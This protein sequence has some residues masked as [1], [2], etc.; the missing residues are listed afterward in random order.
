[1]HIKEEMSSGL[2]LPT[3]R[4]R[5]ATATILS[6]LSYRGQVCHLLQRLSHQSRAFIVSQEGLPGFLARCDVIELI[7]SQQE[8]DQGKALKGKQQVCLETL[9]LELAGLE[10]DQREQLLR[11]HYP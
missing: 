2:P 11:K 1:M 4:S 6:F 5:N 3:L 8:S 7:L 10:A 9:Q